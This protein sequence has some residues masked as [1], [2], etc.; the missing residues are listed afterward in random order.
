MPIFLKLYRCFWH[1]P[2]MCMWFGYN[3][4]IK[5]YYCFSR[6]WYYMCSCVYRW[7]VPCIR[8]SSYSFLPIFLSMYRCFGHDLKMCIWCG[9][10]PQINCITFSPHFELNHYSGSKVRGTDSLKGRGTN[11]FSIK[12]L[13]KS[14]SL[15]RFNI[16]R[17]NRIFVTITKTRLFKYTEHLTTKKWKFSDKN[18]WYFSYSCSKHRL[19]VLVRTASPRRFLRVTTIYVFEQK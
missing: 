2:K 14:E 18:F 13:N 8:N 11:P 1:G 7:W 9:Y 10:N 5:C 6:S 4:Q 3:P 19:W 17:K 12:W 15:V 16:N